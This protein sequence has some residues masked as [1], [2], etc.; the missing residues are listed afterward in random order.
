MNFKKPIT[1]VLII[2]FL[3]SSLACVKS[4]YIYKPEKESFGS[5]QTWI[6]AKE[7]DQWFELIEVKNDSLYIRMNKDFY[8]QAD[9]L[10]IVSLNN[11]S[12]E[13]KSKIEP[14]LW[15]PFLG[16]IVTGATFTFIILLIHLSEA[17][18]SESL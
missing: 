18:D 1:L 10:I 4:V 7:Y 2:S 6:K 17:F 12:P 13:R 5:G 8:S 9:S 14:D 3:L 16:G 11:T 15:A